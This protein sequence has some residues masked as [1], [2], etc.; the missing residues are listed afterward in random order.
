MSNNLHLENRQD[1]EWVRC[2]IVHNN[3]YIQSNT[4][5][6]ASLTKQLDLLYFN[7]NFIEM[8]LLLHDLY[9]ALTECY[10]AS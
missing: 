3:V 2:L 5:S 4:S 8:L 6:Y 10:I 7:S 1:T 9:V